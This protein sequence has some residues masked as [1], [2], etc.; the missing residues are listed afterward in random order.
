MLTLSPARAA[1]LA[2]IDARYPAPVVGPRVILPGDAISFDYYGR[3]VEGVIVRNRVL[4]EMAVD[5]Y[6]AETGMVHGLPLGNGPITRIEDAEAR[7]ARLAEAEAHY[8][9]VLSAYPVWQE[10][11]AAQ[12]DYQ[13]FPR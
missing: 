10:R 12:P 4:A 9:S 11:F 5:A 2:A 1:A 6:C 3:Q 7:A 8:K 13:I